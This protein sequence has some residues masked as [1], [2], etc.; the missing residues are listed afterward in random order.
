MNFNLERFIEAQSGTYQSA[1][2]EIKNGRKTG[3]WM[4]Y[5]FPQLRG[6]GSTPTSQ[7]YAIQSLE[8][9]QCYLRDDLLRKNLTEC[10]EALLSLENQSAQ[11]IFGYPDVLKLCSSLTLFEKASEG[12]P[13]CCLFT[14]ALE[15]YY[16]GQRAQK[17]LLII[18]KS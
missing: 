13:D 14:H 5:I 2:A 11:E 16:L 18:E 15:K 17:T 7:Y 1:L 10:V 12:S 8:E 4:W 3:H 6:L 9:A